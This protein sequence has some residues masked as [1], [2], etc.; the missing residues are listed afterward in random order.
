MASSRD[1]TGVLLAAGSRGEA[2]LDLQ[3]RLSACGH[4]PPAAESGTL[5][6][7][8]SAQLR[9]FQSAR[10]LIANGECDQATWNALVEA[11]YHLGDRLLYL[12]SPMLRGDDVH[13]LQRQ[14]D[15]LGFNPRWLDGIFGPDTE[16]ALKDFQ[17]N[18]G[19]TVDGVCG[20][21]VCATLERLGGA[22]AGHDTGVAEVSER[23]RLRHT[24]RDLHERRVAVGDAG[25]LDTLARALD[26]RLHEAGATV[27]VLHH[28]DPSAQA[29]AANAF[30]AELFV[31]IG[32]T[33]GDADVT[34]YRTD[35]F[36]SEGGQRLA[37]CIREQI[38]P[39][40]GTDQLPV[41]GMRVPLLRETRM[42]AV[43]CLLGPPSVVVEETASIA[44]RLATAVTAWAADPV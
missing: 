31:G 36:T 7:A 17:R 8:T 32:L 9:A 13:A 14:L 41:R 16:Q 3:R 12:R 37:E 18:T 2:V 20:R 19:L 40:L 26:R 11:G 24:P 23:D 4:D 44:D 1:T 38:G 43:L 6:P 30:A 10:G 42:P 29:Q 22:R 39:V 34:Y 21:D 28:P 27:L 25:G 5:G 15:A 33:D 35:G